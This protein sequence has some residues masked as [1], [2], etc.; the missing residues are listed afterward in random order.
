[1]MLVPTALTE[2]GA[3]TSTVALRLVQEAESREL[4]VSFAPD[5][6]WTR[7]VDE[8]AATGAIVR[9]QAA[10]AKELVQL[11]WRTFGPRLGSP[12]TQV[13]ADESLQLAWGSDRYYVDLEI[14]ADGRWEYFYRDRTTSDAEADEGRP[15]ELTT[16]LIK[17][18][19]RVADER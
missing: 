3:T 8:L 19:K 9:D 17:A 5:L 13:T 14:S 11:A 15:E 6:G 4:A 2:S 10:G 16:R 12:L 7:F 1:M 18:L